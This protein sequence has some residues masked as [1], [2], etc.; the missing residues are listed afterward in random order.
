MT[1]H[2]L[3]L[4]IDKNDGTAKY[5]DDVSNGKNCGC[6]CAECKGELIAKNNGKVKV[7]HFAHASGNDSIKCSQTALHRLAKKIMVEEK[8]IP[9]F[10]NGQL[11]FVNVPFVEEE[12]DLG[13]I[14]PDLYA[15]YNGKPVAIEI[16][17]SHPVDDVKFEKIQKHKLTTF[18]IDLSN[19]EF[20]SR[21]EVRKALYNSENIKLLYDE[22]NFMWYLNL[23]RQL[24]LQKGMVKSVNNGIVKDCPMCT[25][26]INGRFVRMRNVSL[27]QCKNCFFACISEDNKCVH[28]LGHIDGEVSRWFLQAN[29]SENRF[30]SLKETNEKLNDFI[31]LAKKM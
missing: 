21:D 16:F 10:N 22:S 29:I 18:E 17:V 30:M 26:K 12:K 20:V 9:A 15:E 27:N 5:I 7:H 6:I 28:C 24:I 14:R 25:V 23:K 11:E 2:Y 4:A 31:I 13:D 3:L 19:I 8:L 1:K